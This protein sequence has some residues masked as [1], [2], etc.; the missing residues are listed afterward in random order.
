MND[1]WLAFGPVL[2][3]EVA[4]AYGFCQVLRLYEVAVVQVGN[5]ACHFQ[6]AVVCPGREVQSG[7]GVLEQGKAFVVG[8]GIEAEQDEFLESEDADE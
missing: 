2:A 4:V 3:V 8:T 6:D 5:G 1:E 7:H